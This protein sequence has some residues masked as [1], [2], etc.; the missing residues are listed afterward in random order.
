MDARHG[1]ASCA[2]VTKAREGCSPV[3]AQQDAYT[4]YW[5]VPCSWLGGALSGPIWSSLGMIGRRSWWLSLEPRGW[6]FTRHAM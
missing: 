3:L 5:L 6:S 1:V 2:F 4:E